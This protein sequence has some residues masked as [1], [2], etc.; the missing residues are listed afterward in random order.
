MF[1]LWPGV[2]GVRDGTSV[3]GV[4]TSFYPV[5]EANTMLPDLGRAGGLLDLLVVAETHKARKPQGDTPALVH[6]CNNQR[7]SRK[8][9]CHQIIGVI[10]VKV[11]S[12]Y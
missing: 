1:M 2:S 9:Q 11:S 7:D 10:G 8:G 6:L 12:D 4:V 5:C 3:K